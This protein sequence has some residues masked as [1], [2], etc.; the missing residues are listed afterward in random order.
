MKYLIRV[1]IIILLLSIMFW[2][3]LVKCIVFYQIV[4]EIFVEMF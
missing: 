3:V 4:E 2:L 1:K